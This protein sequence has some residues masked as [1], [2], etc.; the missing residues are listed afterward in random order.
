MVANT[1]SGA[2]SIFLV[3]S[4]PV[5]FAGST[6]GSEQISNQPVDVLNLLEVREFVPVAYTASLSANIFR[7]VGQSLKQQGIMPTQNNIIESP[8]LEVAI[9][10]NV[11]GATI[12]LFQGVRCAGHNWDI[13]ARGIVSESVEFNAVRVLDE[14]DLDPGA[15]S[16]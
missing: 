6:S 4:V 7:V 9:Q 10:D 1:F 11:T 14:A 16:I 5:A 13:S 15:G 8:D 12:Q 3:N 2:R